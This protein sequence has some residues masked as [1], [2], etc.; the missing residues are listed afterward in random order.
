MMVLEVDAAESSAGTASNGRGK[1]SLAPGERGRWLWT[2]GEL[3]PRR[4]DA[5]HGPRQRRRAGDETLRIYGEEYDL[6]LRMIR[7]AVIARMMELELDTT[8]EVEFMEAVGEAIGVT[9]QTVHSFLLG[10]STKL[11]T[12]RKVLR[13]TGLRWEQVAT[14]VRLGNPTKGTD[15]ALRPSDR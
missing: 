13:F 14:P 2:R 10:N 15:A 5:P 7:Q 9:R 1:G 12:L 3:R 8:T 4:G 6:D 11:E